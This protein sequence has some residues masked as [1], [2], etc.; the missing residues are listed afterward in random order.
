MVEKVANNKYLLFV[1]LIISIIANCYLI[2]NAHRHWNDMEKQQK[3]IV[4]T[5]SGEK[6]ESV[7]NVGK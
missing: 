1:A 2:A 5:C 6:Y 4:L 3:I 7:P